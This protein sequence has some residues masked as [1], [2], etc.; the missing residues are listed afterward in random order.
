[1]HGLNAVL[2]PDHGWYRIDARGNR[3]DVNAQFDPPKERLAF[4]IRIDG[5]ADFRE[6][7]PNPLPSVVAALRTHRDSRALVENLPDVNPAACL[8]TQGSSNANVP[9]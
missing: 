4:A 9:T 5:E 1:L 8:N 3:H 7:L 6:I 2:L